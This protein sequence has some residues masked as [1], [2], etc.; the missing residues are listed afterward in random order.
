MIRTVIGPALFRANVPPQKARLWLCASANILASIPARERRAVSPGYIRTMAISTADGSSPP[1]SGTVRETSVPEDLAF[2]CAVTAAKGPR[3]SM[4]DAHL[5][6][7][8]FAGIRGQALFGVFD[9]H[10]GKEAAKWSSKHYASCLLSVLQQNESGKV[11]DALNQSFR[12]VD[13]RLE[14]FWEASKGEQH[15]G[16][17][18]VVAFIRLED[19]KGG[20]S[21]VPE[22]YEPLGTSVPGEAKSTRSTRHSKSDEVFVPP[23]DVRRVLYT[24]N[25]GDARAVLCRNGKGTRLTYDHKASDKKEAQRIENQ[26]GVILQGRVDGTLIPTRALGDSGMNQYVTSAPHTAEIELGKDDEL[27]ILAC[28]GLWDVMSDQEAVDLVRGVR[29]AMEAADRLLSEA[30]RRRTQDNVTV[31]VIRLRDPPEGVAGE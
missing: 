3:D 18:A 4:E 12:D 19:E 9:G 11:I 6:E 30:R 20:Q 28:D 17:T 7:T 1:S 10:G 5:I 23:A 29:D 13:K 15:S 22:S 24:A 25:V 8:P 21:F 16:C 27:V 26:G 31:L 2:S 14:E